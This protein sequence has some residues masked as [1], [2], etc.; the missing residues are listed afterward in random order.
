MKNAFN[1]I[2]CAAIFAAVKKRAPA[3]LPFAQRAYGSGTPLHTAGSPDDVEPVFYQH[4]VHQGDPL[5]PLLFALTLQRV[6]ERVHERDAVVP[7]A[8]YLDDTNFTGK[9]AAG[10]ALFR[11]LCQDAEGVHSIGAEVSPAK[12]RVHG[13]VAAAVA[14]V[15]GEL[16]IHKQPDGFKAVGMPLG[17]PEHVAGV[18][19]GRTS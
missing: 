15:A 3:R 1:S 16:G 12:C 11:R 4:G 17:S 2:S 19:E 14:T 6:L 8:A 10:V 18:L 5:G 13:G 9:L 7:V